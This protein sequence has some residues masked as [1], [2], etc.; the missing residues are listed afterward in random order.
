MQIPVRQ[1]LCSSSPWLVRFVL[2]V[3]RHLPDSLYTSL[4]IAAGLL[5]LALSCI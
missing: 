5:W 4:A 1:L 3:R 2:P